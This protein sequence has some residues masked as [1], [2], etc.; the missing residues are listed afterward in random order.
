[1]DEVL[2]P[3]QRS[4]ALRLNATMLQS[5]YLRNEGGGKF[6]MTPLPIEAQFSVIN[7][8][9]VDDYDGDGNLDLLMNGNDYSTSVGIGQYDAFYG[10]LLKGDGAG[11]FKPLSMLQSG[12]C[13]SGN[14]KALVKLKSAK[15]GY[16]VAATQR[17]GNLE[18][19]ELKKKQGMV[20]VRPRDRFALLT[21]KNGKT[22]KQELNQG[23]SFLSQSA[24]LLSVGENISAI[25]IADDKGVFHN[26]QIKYP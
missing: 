3:E 13:I 22:Q 17:Q 16:L 26:A 23:S 2:T 24:N 5:V 6:T 8:M 9:V 10:L 7:G 18:I 4:G 19:F 20:N 25:R 11:G 21:L 1:M 14:G 12:I 15:G